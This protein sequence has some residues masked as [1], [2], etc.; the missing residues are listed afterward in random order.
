M[1]GHNP[2][3]RIHLVRQ[4]RSAHVA[5]D[6]RPPVAPIALGRP[7]IHFD[8]QIPVFHQKVM[9]QILVKITGRPPFRDV[10]Q[11]ARAMHEHHRRAALLIARRFIQM[12]GKLRAIPRR[13]FHNGRIEPRIFGEIG[14]G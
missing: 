3:R 5:I 11:I 7:I 2:F 6:R 12:S 10:L 4:I 8:H 13:N 1:L 14:S 9:K